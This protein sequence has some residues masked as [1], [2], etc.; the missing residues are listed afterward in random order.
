MNL[1]IT[2]TYPD[3]IISYPLELISKGPLPASEKA[4]AAICETGNILFK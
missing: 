2:G 3:M 1:A 4:S